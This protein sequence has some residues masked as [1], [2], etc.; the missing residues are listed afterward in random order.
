VY[1]AGRIE[2]ESGGFETRRYAS[3][4]NTSDLSPDF[5]NRASRGRMSGQPAAGSRRRMPAQVKATAAERPLYADG[6]RAKVKGRA[7]TDRRR[8]ALIMERSD[9]R[10]RMMFFLLLLQLMRS[11]AL[12]CRI[13]FLRISR[14]GRIVAKR[15]AEFFST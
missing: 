9:R 12:I 5:S 10:V 6:A 4:T 13:V 3:V 11:A 15:A 2:R 8:T 14:M 1:I 7:M